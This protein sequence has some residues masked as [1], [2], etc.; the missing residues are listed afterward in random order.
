MHA[1]TT[2]DL[3][4]GYGTRVAATGAIV[5]GTMYAWK[6]H[7]LAGVLVRSIHPAQ[8]VDTLAL[9]VIP[10]E[11]VWDR[12]VNAGTKRAASHRRTVARTRAAADASW[13]W[14]GTDAG[15]TP[16]LPFPRS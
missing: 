9:H 6:M 3:D 1:E 13:T 2:L 5:R 10:G 15:G 7:G 8:A 4:E 16:S 11:W 14:P 12:Y